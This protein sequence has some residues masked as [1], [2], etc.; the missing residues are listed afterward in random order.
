MITKEEWLNSECIHEE[1]YFEGYYSLIGVYK[2][3]NCKEEI[4]PQDYHIIEKMP[5]ISRNE[6]GEEEYYNYD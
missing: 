5:F 1:V 4:D 3:F 2:C 6:K